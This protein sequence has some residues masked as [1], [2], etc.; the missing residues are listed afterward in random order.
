MMS[1]RPKQDA[2]DERRRMA[3]RLVERA[4][5]EGLFVRLAN[6]QLIEPEKYSPR[7]RAGG[8]PPSQLAKAR[9]STFPVKT[10]YPVAPT[11][12]TPLAFSLPRRRTGQ[13]SP[14]GGRVGFNRA[15]VSGAQPRLADPPGPVHGSDRSLAFP[16]AIW[17]FSRP[18]PSRGTAR[19]AAEAPTAYLR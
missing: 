7:P 3:E 5:A 11:A 19:E 2:T 6:G 13:T 15:A 18:S 10:S 9:A 8:P 16:H 4:I 12:P 17:H 1:D 14:G